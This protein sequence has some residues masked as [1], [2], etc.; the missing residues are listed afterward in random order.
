MA[1]K[2]NVCWFGSGADQSPSATGQVVESQVCHWEVVLRA[3]VAD[4]DGGIRNGRMLS[5]DL[6]NGGLSIQLN[7]AYPLDLAVATKADSLV[8]GIISGSISVDS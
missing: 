8:A 1:A 3:L 4:L 7:P 2:S 6:A 5:A